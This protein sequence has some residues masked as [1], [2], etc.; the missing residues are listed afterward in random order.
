[1]HSLVGLSGSPQANRC[2]C[3][4]G[5]GALDGRAMATPPDETEATMGRR[6]KTFPST[7]RPFPHDFRLRQPAY[8]QDVS[9]VTRAD[10]AVQHTYIY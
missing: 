2:L 5:W 4:G 6:A 10:R 9:R 7:F 3:D 1:M 8:C